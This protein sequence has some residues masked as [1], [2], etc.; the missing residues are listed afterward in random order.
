MLLRRAVMARISL[1]FIVALF[2]SSAVAQFSEPTRK[3]SKRGLHY[4]EVVV[5]TKVPFESC[6]NFSCRTKEV[7]LRGQLW[8]PEKGDPPY[9]LVVFSHGAQTDDV[10]STYPTGIEPD[11]FGLA[12]EYFQMGYAV[13]IAWR[14]GRS[15]ND[16]PRSEI[17]ADS[18]E[19]NRCSD[20][21]RPGLKSALTDLKAYLMTM[22]SRGDIDHRRILLMGHS[23]GG[24]TSLGVAAESVPG[25][26]GVVNMSGMWL[27][28]TARWGNPG[29]ACGK[30][31]NEAF[32]REF[33]EK[34]KVPVLSL[35]GSQDPLAS[36]SHIRSL[37]SRLGKNAPADFLIVDGAGH[38][39]A[40]G[41]ARP[42][43]EEKQDRFLR[44][45]IQ[46]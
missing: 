45:A 7:T 46:P 44:L 42:A 27:S 6:V 24:A 28:E 16:L 9:K 31:E 26:V 10:K 13:L 17:S 34:L 37:L 22:S 41:S 4:Q 8:L 14:K 3:V 25:V 1:G 23:R 2:F 36:V 40:L 39:V 38:G 18:A 32:F 35:Y 30:G 11:R 29:A 21:M 19:S 33:G 43:W 5:T 12:G 15:A 20:D